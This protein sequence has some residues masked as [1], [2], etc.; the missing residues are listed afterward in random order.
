MAKGSKWDR[1]RSEATAQRDHFKLKTSYRAF[2]R[3]RA[4]QRGMS[5]FS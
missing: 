4:I 2:G 1:L 3:L 5:L